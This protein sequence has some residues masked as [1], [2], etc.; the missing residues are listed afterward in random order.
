MSTNSLKTVGEPGR[1]RT[2]NPLIKSRNNNVVDFLNG[3][4]FIVR[5]P[6]DPLAEFK[7]QTGAYSAEFGHSAGAVVNASIKA[8][9]NHIHGDF[10]EY[11]RNDAF[12]IHQEFDG[13]N[14][15]PKY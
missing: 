6:P 12:D 2:C 15:V 8:G 1:T 7:I 11:L 14:P 5:P 13:N 3:A 10:W 4:S 9:T